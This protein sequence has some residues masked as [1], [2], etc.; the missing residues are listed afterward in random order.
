MLELLLKTKGCTLN[1]ETKSSQEA[2][3]DD[4]GWIV[5][6]RGCSVMNLAGCPPWS[7]QLDHIVYIVLQQQQTMSLHYPHSN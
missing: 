2:E 3:A 7:V 4:I 6:F 5:I 1:G